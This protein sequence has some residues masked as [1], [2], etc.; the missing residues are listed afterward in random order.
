MTRKLEARTLAIFLIG[1]LVIIGLHSSPLL[2]MNDFNSSNFLLFHTILE[3]LSVSV[4]LSIAMQ[5]WF[6]FP[7]TLSQHRLFIAA[8]FFAI[9]IFDVF[10][11]LSYQGMPD[12]WS[13]ASVQKS[14]CFWIAARITLATSLLLILSRK[15]RKISKTFRNRVFLLSIIYS[16]T[17]SFIILFYSDHLPLLATD[18]NGPTALKKGMEYGISF[19][20]FGAALI[21][22][23]NYKTTRNKDLLPLLLALGFGLYS[24]WIFTLYKNAYDLNSLLGHLFKVISYGCFLKYLY[25]V[26]IERPY[27]E[28]NG[29]QKAIKESE[30]QLK[31]IVNTVPNG[32]AITDDTGKPLFINK[33][34]GSLLGLSQTAAADPNVTKDNQPLPFL[35]GSHIPLDRHTFIQLKETGKP[36]YDVICKIN[37]ADGRERILSVNSAPIYDEDSQKMQVINS[38]TDI[39]EQTEAQKRINYL[40][41]YDQLT[42]L[43]NRI[44]F[45]KIIAEK[46]EEAPVSGKSLGLIAFNLNRFKLVNE[47]LGSSIG[48]LFL[49]NIATRLQRFAEEH[50]LTVARLNGDE[51]GLLSDISDG[52]TLKELAK[53]AVALIKKPMIAK[54]IKFRISASAGISCSSKAKD[55]EQLLKQAAMAISETRKQN[56]K[57]LVYHPDMDREAYELL[58]LENDLHRAIERTQL[59]LHYQPQINLQTGKLIGAEAL[60]RWNHPD[61]GIISPGTFIPIAEDTG[62]IVPIG[63]WVIEEACRQLRSWIDEGLPAIRISV[64]LSL[65]Q[66]FQEDLVDIVANAL[67]TWRIDPH[68]FELEITESMTLNMDRALKTLKKLKGLGVQIAVDDFGTGYSSLSYLHRFPVDR[69]KIDQSFIRNLFV[70]AS[71]EAIVETIISMGHHLGLG[72]IAEGVET[73]EQVAFLQQHPCQHIQGYYIS[74][75]LPAKEFQHL[76]EKGEFIFMKKVSE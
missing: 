21:V 71:S 66:F 24:E 27:L 6:I 8:L 62:L 41:Y 37:Q 43:P 74:K 16:M 45:K 49:K 33:A 14:T 35:D 26:T 42:G 19:L 61:K 60:I 4:A 57:I 40:A 64:N 12:F 76:L 53:E 29:M 11:T 22:M 50:Q 5:G 59:S 1:L 52:D 9:G 13:E 75:P 10:H 17:I 58:M 70:E 48:D 39:T 31:T 2:F 23:K 46:L 3:L 44:Y 67:Q 7:H 72:L 20:L 63:K 34:A 38:L 28:Q 65:R 36:V 69:L 18:D 47:S 51:F 55:T 68:Y 54:G 15:D 56:A 25:A 73:R 32:I 30:K